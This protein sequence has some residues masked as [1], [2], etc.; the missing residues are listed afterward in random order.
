M[1]STAHG[2]AIVVDEDSKFQQYIDV[3]GNRLVVVDFSASWCGPC[4]MMAPI[5][6]QLSVKYS[7]A[8]F[9][10]VDTD[11]CKM[12][13]K[14]N[15]IRMMP[16]FF[17][18]KNRK[19]VDEMLG[20]DPTGLEDKIN[21]WI[22]GAVDSVIVDPKR[23]AAGRS[24]DCFEQL[25]DNP[26][27]VFMDVSQLLLKFASNII[28]SPDNPKFRSIRVGNK[29]FQSRLLPVNGAVECLF[30]MGFKER[31]NQ[32]VCPQ[33]ESLENMLILQDA[34]IDERARRS[35]NQ[36]P[37]SRPQ[38]SQAPGCPEEALTGCGQ[39]SIISSLSASS[40]MDNEKDFLL[41][42]QSLLQHVLLYEDEDL[43]RR[44]RNIIPI[45]D[46]MKKAKE[47][48]EMTKRGGEAGVSEQDCL[49]LE[50]LNWFKGSFFKWVDK[51]LCASCGS[52]T[53]AIGVVPPTPEEALW[54]AGNVES[55]K[56][57]KCGKKTRF[58]RYNHPA[59][60]LETRQGRCGEWANCFTLIC[61]AVGF[62]SRHV[63]DWTDHVWTEIYSEAQQRWLHCD[64]CENTCDKPLIYEAGWGK[65]LSYI[66]AFSHEQVLDVTWRYSAKHDEVRKART[67]VSEDWL[68]KALATLTEERQINLSEERRKVLMERQV[69]ELVEFFTIKTVRDGELQGRVS[70]DLAWRLLRGE[71]KPQQE[72]YKHDPYI[73]KPTDEEIKEKRL[74][75]CFNCVVN[76]YLRGFD[77]KLD[78]SDW[79]SRVAAYNSITRKVETDWK[80]TYLARTE[81]SSSG[82]ITWQVDLTSCDLVID[83][84][85][86]VATSATFQTGQAEWKLSGDD[87]SQSE[88]L[89]GGRESTIT[90][91]LSGSKTLKLTATLSGG[92]G[93][94]AWQHAQLFR[95]PLDSQSEYPLDVAIFLREPS[96][97]TRL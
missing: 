86:I 57:Q 88:I 46:L 87:E 47:S 60:L 54:G 96:R 49:I 10:T 53:F 11:Q 35:T 44:T 51:P 5:F 85:T 9:L 39:P 29:I 23:V 71:T 48:S 89:S 95:Q 92:K 19:K 13:A 45:T 31:G 24:W 97:D 79:Q 81:S 30:T 61:R 14:I 74:R 16:T 83:S 55:Y 62:D 82:S 33:G 56:C 67:L 15:G 58:P 63:L 66:I 73:Y 84:V 93:N 80:M 76:K 28:N 65:K 70:G 8:I 2:N 90:S 4:R 7:A 41:R 77:R 12:T 68:E 32:L 52:I 18:Y 78:I 3:A 42:L 34:L 21:Q 72:E 17:F 43:Q 50:L 94:V 36:E 20:A 38:G 6:A 27:D 40:T 75:F 22:G 1:A 64:A 25:L 59:K 91:V 37:A 26:P 69:K